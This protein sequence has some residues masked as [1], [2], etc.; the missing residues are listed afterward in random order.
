LEDAY[1]L[2]LLS[3]RLRNNFQYAWST[4]DAAPIRQNGQNNVVVPA[5]ADRQFFR[6][7]KP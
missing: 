5:A 1:L 7:T 4:L 6:L 3:R 2:R